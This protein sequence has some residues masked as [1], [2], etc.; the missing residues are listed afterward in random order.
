VHF[1]CRRHDISS[2]A[3]DFN[4]PLKLQKWFSSAV[5]T[6]L[7]LKYVVPTALETAVFLQQ[8][9][10]TRCYRIYLMPNGIFT[11]CTSYFFNVT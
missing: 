6:K 3:V 10:E 8:R 9:V 4:P 1:E 5:G 11:K 7:M 2:V